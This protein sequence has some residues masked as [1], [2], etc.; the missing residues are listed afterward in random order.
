M[1][2]N[3]IPLSKSFKFSGGEIQIQLP[4]LKPESNKI[5]V[6]TILDSSD[7]IMELVMVKEA[8]TYYY[9]TYH[10]E[11][12]IYYFPYARQDRRCVDR[13]SFS[14]VAFCD[15][16]NTLNFHTVKIADIHSK[17]LLPFFKSK[18]ELI[19]QLDIFKTYPQILDGVDVLISPDRGALL[20]VKEIANHFN[21]HYTFAEKI[22][23]PNNGRIEHCE[24]QCFVHHL[25]DKNILIIDDII[26]G[27]ATFI[28]LIEKLKEHKPK[29]IALY[30][31]HGIFSKGF[32]IFENI[33]LR[34]VF[35]TDSRNESV[36]IHSEL[37][38]ILKLENVK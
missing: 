21:I 14:G 26:D 32:E 15:L 11:L 19:T 18:V 30:A 7:K 2:I 37:I 33:G 24:I 28:T 5:I 38:E 17:E 12:I 27:G 1:L 16:L 9:S 23:N 13:E 10:T 22:R 29:S 25:K 3:G 20:K 31:T 4:E 35:V 6:E 36:S 8:L 34:K